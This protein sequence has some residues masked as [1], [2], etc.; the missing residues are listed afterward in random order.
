[1]CGVFVFMTLKTDRQSFILELIAASR[2]ERQDEIVDAL[3]AKGFGVTQASVSRDLEELGIV[4][5]NGAYTQRAMLQSFGL[6]LVSIVPAGPN[7]L[8]ARCMPGLASATAVRI[9]AAKIKEIVGTIAGDDTIFLAID[10][11]KAQSA[12]TEKVKAMFE[13]ME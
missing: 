8:V 12:V 7:M 5:A 9:D 2:I 4:K 11:A 13:G 10:D 1:M 3:K 6:R